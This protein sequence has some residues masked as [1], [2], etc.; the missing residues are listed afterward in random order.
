MKS[1]FKYLFASILGVILASILMFFIFF[2]ILSAIIS[3]EEEVYEV[4]TNSVLHLK[5][6]KIIQD[7]APTNPMENFDF[8]SMES[9]TPLGLDMIVENIEKASADKNIKGIFLDINYVPAGIATIDEIRN[10]LISF[11]DSS[12]FIVC[13]SS[14]M[15]QSAYYLASVADK[16]YLQ[17][18]G[19][20]EFKGLSAEVMFFKGALEKLEVDAQIIRHGKYKSAVEPFM[21]DKM[22]DQSREQLLS[23]LD[24]VWDYM[25]KD[26]S[27]R[28]NVGIT[29][30]NLIADSLH[31]RKA[32]DAVKYKLIDNVKYYDE[33]IDELKTMCGIDTDKNL[34]KVSLADY[35]TV[36]KIRKGKGL[37]KDKIAV[38]FASG[39]IVNDGGGGGNITPES[40]SKAIRKAREDDAV[41]A[42]V[43]RINSPG[44]SALA[45]DIIWR[46]TVL[47]QK[48]KPLIVSMGDVA[49]SGGYYIACAADTILASPVTI[50]GSIGV[51]GVLPNAQKFFSNKLGITFDRANTNTHADMISITRGL[52]TTEQNYMTDM[53]EDI[54]TVFVGHVAEGRDLSQTQVDSIGQ[55]RIWS[56]IHATE[57]GLVDLHGG[58]YKAIQIAAEKAGL[59]YYRTISLPEQKDTF[60]AI[61]ESI[62]G[63]EKST[64]MQKEL[65]YAYKY[66]ETIQ[67][68]MQMEGIQTIMP[69]FMYVE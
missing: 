59:N 64:V 18:E 27:A 25:L 62:T 69:F 26:I 3:S 50:T 17:P 60:E 55:G 4:K 15:T 14:Y 10:A 5:L 47:A 68:L 9:N 34:E 45:S 16:I 21:N 6:D 63:E 37:A 32:E 53:I 36:P 28:R 35:K 7:R 19:S 51:L 33:V 42:I 40:I 11:K 58:L 1:F 8:A 48:A 67:Q 39:T 46:E 12:K 57:N 31:I 43:L 2:G 52:T 66:Y 22:S 23:Y 24:A 30:L 56:G 49:A 44:G 65:G 38:I 41:K 20:L 61:L 54:Y 13:Y 29:E